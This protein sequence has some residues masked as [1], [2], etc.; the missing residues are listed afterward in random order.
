MCKVADPSCYEFSDNQSYRNYDDYNKSQTGFQSKQIKEGSQEMHTCTD[1]VRYRNDESGRYGS[2]IILKSV[3]Y[4]SGVMAFSSV[5]LLVK[6]DIEQ[7]ASEAVPEAYF[8]P[9]LKIVPDGIEE[10][11]ENDDADHESGP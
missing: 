9:C 2:Y 6:K 4:I 10:D 1:K 7:S 8:C 11:P 5:I 3:Y